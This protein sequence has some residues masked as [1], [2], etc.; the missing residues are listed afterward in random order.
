MEGA[1]T[2]NKAVLK[3]EF[4]SD[5]H[6]CRKMVNTGKLKDKGAFILVGCREVEAIF[7][8]QSVVCL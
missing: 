1:I 7:F 3:D 5:L 2:I 6:W 4:T 8:S